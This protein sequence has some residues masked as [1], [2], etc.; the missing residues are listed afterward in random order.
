VVEGEREVMR[1]SEKREGGKGWKDRR[2]GK[3]VEM[4]R[5]EETSGRETR[6]RK[7]VRRKERERNRW[8]GEE[9]MEKGGEER[10]RGRKEM[11]RGKCE[12]RRKDGGGEEWEVRDFRRGKR[13]QY[14]A[15]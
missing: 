12:G 4:R 2:R 15:S 13:S 7:R 1:K 3:I 5:G 14:P 9:E 10:R 8:E 6:S 11:R